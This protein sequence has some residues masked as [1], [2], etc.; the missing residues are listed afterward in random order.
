MS[1]PQLA[2]AMTAGWVF[3]FLFVLE[4]MKI[5]KLNIEWFNNRYY[6]NEV[7]YYKNNM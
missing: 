6:R 4:K 1:K 3:V 2:Q 5:D 7:F